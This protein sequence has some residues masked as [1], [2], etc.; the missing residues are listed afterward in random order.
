MDCH[1]FPDGT[2]ISALIAVIYWHD[3]VISLHLNNKWHQNLC[4]SIIPD[5][6]KSDRNQSVD[7]YSDCAQFIC[8]SYISFKSFPLFY[9]LRLH[10]SFSFKLVCFCGDS[11]MAY[12]DSFTCAPLQISLYLNV[13]FF[14]I[15]MTNT[16]IHPAFH[17]F[18]WMPV[19]I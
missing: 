3:T 10:F 19:L 5:T 11:V 15:W 7:L 9:G 17:V 16:P 12:N 13:A 2:N 18:Y 1:P 4:S 8:V 14:L 6:S